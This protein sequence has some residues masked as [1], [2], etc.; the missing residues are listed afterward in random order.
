MFRRKLWGAGMG[1]E[2]EDHDG[3]DD[4]RGGEERDAVAHVKCV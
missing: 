2:Q 1:L 4:Q 3:E